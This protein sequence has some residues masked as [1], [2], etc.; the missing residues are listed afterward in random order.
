MISEPSNF[1]VADSNA[2]AAISSTQ[3]GA[4]RGRIVVAFEHRAP[5]GVQVHDLTAHGSAFEQ[6]SLQGVGM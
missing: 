5:G 6:E 1:N 3:R 4:Q 2:A